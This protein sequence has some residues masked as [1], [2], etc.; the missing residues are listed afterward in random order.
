MA[1]QRPVPLGI[2]AVISELRPAAGGG[3]ATWDM[4]A[5]LT[6]DSGSPLWLRLRSMPDP[7]LWRWAGVSYPTPSKNLVV[8]WV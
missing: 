1:F 5:G 4:I 6:L 8:P 2:G 3:I 7:R